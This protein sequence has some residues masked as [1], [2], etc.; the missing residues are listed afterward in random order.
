MLEVVWVKKVVF[1]WTEDLFWKS[2][3]PSGCSLSESVVS[4]A[5]HRSTSP[6]TSWLVPSSHYSTHSHSQKQGHSHRGCSQAGLCRVERAQ[7]SLTHSL[8]VHRMCV[9]LLNIN[10]A[11]FRGSAESCESMLPQTDFPSVRNPL[12]LIQI[13]IQMHDIQNK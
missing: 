8:H 12:P 4:P 13:S 11:L 10:I 9:E 1:M 2:L 3:D 6:F 7:L 5:V